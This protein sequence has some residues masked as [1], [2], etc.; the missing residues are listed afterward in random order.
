MKLIKYMALTVLSLS[1]LS[2]GTK[3]DYNVLRMNMLTEPDSFYPW[4]SASTDTSA[5]NYNIYEGLMGFDSTGAVYPNL[6]RE[7]TISEDKLTYT[8]KLHQGITFH[9]GQELTAEDVV[10]TYENLAG[11]NGY[12]KRNDK[13][14]I[15]EEVK[16]LDNYTV[17]VKLSKPA[18]GFITLAINPILKKGFDYSKTNACG[19]GPYKLDKYELHQKIVLTKNENYWNPEKAGKIPVCEIYIISDESAAMAALKSGQLDMIQAVTA[20]NAKILEKKYKVNYEPQ[21]MSQIF[22]MNTSKGP[23]SDLNVRLAISCAVNKQAVINGALDGAATEIYSNFSPIM[24]EYYNDQLSGYT[25][26]NLKKAKEYMAASAYP[27]GFDLEITVPSNYPM[28]VNAA[29]IISDQLKELN[30]NC[31]LKLI[32]WTTWLDQVY[33]KANYEATVIAFS[34]KLDPSE[35]LIRYVSTYKRN[36]TRFNDPEYDQIFKMAETETDNTKRVELYKK[37][38][39]ILTVKAPAVFICDIY[40][41]VAMDKNL[42]GFKQYPVSYYPLS[43]MYYKN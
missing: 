43:E 33:S 2:C 1:L 15:V 4:E 40:N 16:A 41:N 14:H 18:A 6:A 13:L 32:E 27:Q 34:G 17:A 11:L 28:H 39:E 12:T 38:Q 30:I 25:P 20:G 24:A 19:T 37:C 5:L 42:M 3:K 29:Q 23:L 10:W 9:N 8:F 21:N 31:S 35:I 36:F 7:Y 26:Y 22:G